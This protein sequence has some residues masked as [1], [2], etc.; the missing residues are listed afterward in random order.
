MTDKH[1]NVQ[2][3]PTTLGAVSKNTSETL[4]QF[5]YDFVEVYKL[6][7]IRKAKSNTEA[8]VC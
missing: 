1:S 5:G 3:K 8:T 7:T 6:L 4:L 2:L